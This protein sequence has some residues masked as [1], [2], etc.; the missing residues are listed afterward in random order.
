MIH[1]PAGKTGGDIVFY[2]EIHIFSRFPL[3]AFF[4]YIARSLR[5]V[6]PVWFM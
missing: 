3:S 4:F 6:M 1:V 5:K 2:G